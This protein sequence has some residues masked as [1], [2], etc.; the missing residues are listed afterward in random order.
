MKKHRLLIPLAILLIAFL[1]MQV[2]NAMSQPQSELGVTNGQLA[3]CPDKPNCVSSQASEGHFVEPLAFETDP[4]TAWTVLKQ[5]VAEFPRASVV[6]EKDNYMRCEFRSAVLRFVD[7]VEFLLDDGRFVI[8]VRSASRIGYSDLG[9]NRQR[10]E[11]LRQKLA[12]MLNP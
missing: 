3:E 2:L 6:K 1:G 5:V 11:K 7:D 10:V 8:H 12:A 9:A 4:A